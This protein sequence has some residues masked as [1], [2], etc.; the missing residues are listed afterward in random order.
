LLIGDKNALF[1]SS[2]RLAYGDNYGPLKITCKHCQ[3]DSE[4]TIDLSVIK[5]KEF[6]FS[7]FEKG[8]NSFKFSLPYSKHEIEYKIPCGEDEDVI[9]AELKSLQKINKNNSSEITTRLKNIIVSVNGNSDKGAIRKFVDTELL[10]RD[11]I[12]LRNNIKQNTPDL[13]L[14]FDFTCEQCDKSERMDV[15]MTVQFFWPTS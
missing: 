12:A 11:S 14:N 10:S 6:D 4:T 15:P 7:K 3:Q 13:D 8:K 2:R 9:E 5:N 1:I